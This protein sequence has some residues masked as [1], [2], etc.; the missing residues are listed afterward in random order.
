LDKTVSLRPA[1]E[2]DFPAIKKLIRKARINP[3]GLDWRRFTVAAS[4]LAQSK[5]ET[6]VL[7]GCVQLKPVPGDLV[8][9]ASLV[10]RPDFRGQGLARLLIEHILAES[11]RPLYLTCRPGLG[12]FYEKFGFRVLDTDEIPR[13]YLRLQRIIGAL[14][15]LTLRNET[16]FVM[17]L[18]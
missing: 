15:H 16:L 3:T 6:S 12:V 14:T 7:V 17:M 2:A 10:V 8:E 11:P 9:L 18:G 5:D 4:R 13:Y 1:V